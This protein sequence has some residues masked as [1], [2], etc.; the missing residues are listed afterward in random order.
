MHLQHHGQ[1]I[2]R[3]IR[4]HNISLSEI[5][6]LLQ[7]NR[8]AMYKWFTL[9]T[10]KPEIIYRLGHVIQHDFSVEFPEL[11]KPEDFVLKAKSTPLSN[12]ERKILEAEK[13]LIYKEKYLDLLERYGEL[14]IKISQK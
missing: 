9:Q 13:E 5:A 12:E 7:V 14:V 2:E 1:I 6:R 8:R 11:F 10:L 4:K 3:I